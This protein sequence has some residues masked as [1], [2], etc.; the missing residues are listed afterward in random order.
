MS[1]L[2]RPDTWLTCHSV[3]EWHDWLAQN[4]QQ[5]TEVWLLIRKAA[6][7]ATDV[8][9]AAA[10]ATPAIPATPATA[11][12]PAT[13]EGVHLADAVTEAVRFG[14]IDSRMYSLGATHYVLRFSPRQPDSI[15]ALNN[16]QKAEALIAAGQMEPAGLAAVEAGKASGR[17]QTAYNSRE[18]PVIPEYLSDALKG[19]PNP[20]VWPAFEKWAPSMKIQYIFWI[21]DAK[22]PETR[23]KRIDALIQAIEQAARR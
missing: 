10:P 13:T 2:S 8:T 9:D 21:E 11:T 19:A 18:E 12:T 6:P 16:R 17:W 4:H 3:Q 22:R 7:P 1:K 14:W 20:A 15:W 5:A 23:Q